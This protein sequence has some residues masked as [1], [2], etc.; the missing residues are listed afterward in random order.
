MHHF[1]CFVL[2]IF[3]TN[4]CEKQTLPR[5]K[6]YYDLT[7]YNP[8]L[9]NRDAALIKP[10]VTGPK[11]SSEDMFEEHVNSQTLPYQGWKIYVSATPESMDL[12]RGIVEPSL[13]LFSMNYKV[14]KSREAYNQL[15]F[16]EEERGKYFTVYP[17][18]YDEAFKISHV[19]N[20]S[21]IPL[22]PDKF[23]DLPYCMTLGKSGGLFTRYGR[24][25][26]GFLL[27]EGQVL[28]V[29]KEDQFLQ[30][31]DD[32]KLRQTVLKYNKK[33]EPDDRKF[34]YPTFIEMDW[35]P[36]GNLSKIFQENEDTLLK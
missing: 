25:K 11:L 31:T 20:L 21:L 29:S 27:K 32:L 3:I 35:L 26:H 5:T 2:F 9:I 10:P 14:I 22:T 24:F 6:R 19:L 1:I 34:V 23:M 28:A 30:C 17:R 36:F 15:N 16:N 18:N 8:E 7:T 12:I 33:F 13:T 4:A